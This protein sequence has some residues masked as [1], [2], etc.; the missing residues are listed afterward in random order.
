M[1]SCGAKKM[2]WLRLRVNLSGVASTSFYR[3]KR[4]IKI[5]TQAKPEYLLAPRLITLEIAYALTLER[6]GIDS[7]S[8]GPSSSFGS[9]SSSG[10]GGNAGSSN[11]ST[12]GVPAYAAELVHAGDILVS[13]ERRESEPFRGT[14]VGLFAR[15]SG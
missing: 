3:A 13:D 8:S 12:G 15:P 2:T 6:A 11:A 1:I 7:P 4:D 14:C 10:G 9:S 5:D